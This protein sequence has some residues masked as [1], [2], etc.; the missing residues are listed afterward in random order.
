MKKI[1]L[2]S[3]FFSIVMMAC[4]TSA[5]A[6]KFDAAPINKEADLPATNTTVAGS[7]DSFVPVQNYLPVQPNLNSIAPALN[8]A[9][10]KPGHRCD[11]AV[12]APLNSVATKPAAT[13]TSTPLPTNTVN[14]TAPSNTAKLNPA[15]GKPGHRCDIAV[16]APLNSVAATPATPTM[17]ASQPTDAANATASSNTI[18]LNPAHGKPGHDCTIAVGQPLKQ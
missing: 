13:A 5:D 15:H 9:H 2:G 10:G 16:G 8:P 11:I 17:P 4:D 18:K 6:V 1:Y 12:G 14:A 3:L 7:R